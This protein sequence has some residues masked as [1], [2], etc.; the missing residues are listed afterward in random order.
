MVAMAG[1]DGLRR[2]SRWHRS[3]DSR[4]FDI[5][6]IFYCR[7]AGA[8]AIGCSSRAEGPS[9]GVTIAPAA[10][11]AWYVVPGGVR[12]PKPVPVTLST[13]VQAIRNKACLSRGRCELKLPTRNKRHAN[14]YRQREDAA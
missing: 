14:R 10:A 8:G 6:A 5:E 4:E 7:G 9:L 2:P 3:R 11:A 13:T 12:L 1:L